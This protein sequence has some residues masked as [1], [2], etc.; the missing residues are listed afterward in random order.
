MHESP[1]RETEYVALVKK[2]MVPD[3]Y[4]V[5]RF[6]LKESLVPRKIGRRCRGG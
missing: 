6:A 5:G 3:L 4:T 2:R 1:Q